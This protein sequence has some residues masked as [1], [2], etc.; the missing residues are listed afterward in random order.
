MIVLSKVISIFSLVLIHLM[1][2]GLMFVCLISLFVGDVDLFQLQAFFVLGGIFWYLSFLR[3]VFKS[4][5][6]DSD[7]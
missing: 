5:R 4:S 7:D 2:L 1:S 6:G 3:I